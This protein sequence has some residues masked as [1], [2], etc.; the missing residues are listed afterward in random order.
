[1]YKDK[2]KQKT[3]NKE[4]AQRRRDKQQ[5]MTDKGMTQSG[6]VIPRVTPSTSNGIGLPANFGQP[7]CECQHCQANKARGSRHTLNHGPWKTREQLDTHELNRVSLPGDVDY[8]RS[9]EVA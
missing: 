8:K 5:G 6:N 2:E 7:D 9:K 4:A 1:M 3:A